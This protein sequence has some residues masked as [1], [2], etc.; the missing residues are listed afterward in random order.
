MAKV[1]IFLDEN[2]T[3]QDAEESIFKALNHHSSGDVHSHHQFQDPGMQSIADRMEDIHSKIYQDMMNE[4]FEEL[5]KEY[6]K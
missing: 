1:K 2:E 3:I 4:I 5:D 6:V